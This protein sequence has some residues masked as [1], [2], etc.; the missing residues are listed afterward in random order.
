MSFER[1][2]NP[3]TICRS[4][5]GDA[6]HRSQP[7]APWVRSNCAL[8]TTQA[9]RI[10]AARTFPKLREGNSFTSF[11][12]CI[13]LGSRC[14]KLFIQREDSFSCS[15]QRYIHGIYM[16]TRAEPPGPKSASKLPSL[17][18][19]PLSALSKYTLARHCRA[20]WSGHSKA[21]GAVQT[22]PPHASDETLGN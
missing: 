8:H 14:L 6:L 20:T 2:L 1:I 21:H 16:R 12:L 7:Q 10:S 19:L 18:S 5:T 9:H 22:R 3:R 17:P 15:R 11:Q 4:N 13:Q